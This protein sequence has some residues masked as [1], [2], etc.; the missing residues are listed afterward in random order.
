MFVIWT[1]KF[2][3]VKAKTPF[4]EAPVYLWTINRKMRDFMRDK[5]KKKVLTGIQC[6]RFANRF[7][8]FV[9]RLMSGHFPFT[10]IPVTDWEV[11][12]ETDSNDAL[13]VCTK[14]VNCRLVYC[15]SRMINWNCCTPWLI[16]TVEPIFSLQV[17]AP[18]NWW[19][20]Y[21]R[22]PVGSGKTFAYLSCMC[23]ADS[24]SLAINQ[25][26]IQW[27]NFN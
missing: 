1:V 19:L 20:N 23:S 2:M 27:L 13:L 22:T 3:G 16:L 12:R 7:F 4:L 24:P 9:R 8:M 10:W 15:S 18:F 25:L 21:P 5:C 11:E 26:I 14:A 17:N 6:G